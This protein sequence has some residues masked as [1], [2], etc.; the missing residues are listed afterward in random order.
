MR[1]IGRAFSSRR[2]LFD[3]YFWFLI[4][5]IWG[6]RSGKG[7]ASRHGSKWLAAS[8]GNFTRHV[9]DGLVSYW[10]AQICWQVT[11][12][13]DSDLSASS[14]LTAIIDFTA[15]Q[16]LKPTSCCFLK[17]LHALPIITSYMLILWA[18]SMAEPEAMR[19]MRRVNVGTRRAAREMIFV[20]SAH[21]ACKCCFSIFFWHS[22]NYLSIFV[23]LSTAFRST[24]KAIDNRISTIWRC[25]SYCKKAYFHSHIRSPSVF[26][27][28]NMYLHAEQ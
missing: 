16:I 14:S 4:H 15:I 22:V 5:C 21:T 2:L 13:P 7:K 10:A 9:P 3:K 19:T 24:N 17:K 27:W 18:P 23:D 8:C 11:E 12:H 6:K 26:F 25:S 20:S 28:N 1:H